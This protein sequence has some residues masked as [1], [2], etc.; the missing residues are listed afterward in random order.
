MRLYENTFCVKGL[1]RLIKIATR[2]YSKQLSQVATSLFNVHANL[3]N[4]FFI[5][6]LFWL[7]IFKYINQFDLAIIILA[8]ESVFHSKGCF[9][10]QIITCLC[11]FWTIEWYDFSRKHASN[12]FKYTFW[13]LEF[14][15][16]HKIHCHDHS[17]EI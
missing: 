2:Y 5:S 10:I 4:I 3:H 12:N 7:H 1:K 14:N 16:F 6:L 17:L 15:M 8:Y 9:F 13:P 11:S